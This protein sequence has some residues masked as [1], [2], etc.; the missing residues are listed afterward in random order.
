MTEKGRARKFGNVKKEEESKPD[1]GA[2]LWAEGQPRRQQ[3]A[4]LGGAE[5]PGLLHVFS[6]LHVSG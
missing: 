2:S 4:R 5:A 3:A 1:P 6:F